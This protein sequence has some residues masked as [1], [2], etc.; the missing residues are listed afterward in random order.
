MLL[1]SVRWNTYRRWASSGAVEYLKELAKEATH[2]SKK[3]EEGDDTQDTRLRYKRMQMYYDQG[4]AYSSLQ[5]EEQGLM[6]MLEEGDKEL[7]EL[8]EDDLKGV[9]DMMREVE[10]SFDGVLEMVDDEDKAD[11]TLE[12]SGGAGGQEADLFAK[13][14]FDVYKDYCKRMGWR[15]ED[16]T[17]DV[18]DDNLSEHHL[19][20]TLTARVSGT[21]VFK[22][23]KWESGVHRVQRIPQSESGGRTHTS[24]AGVKVL[25]TFEP[26]DITVSFPREDFKFTSS[27]NTGPGGQSVNSTNTL[28]I[29]KHI[30]TGMVMKE[31]SGRDLQNNAA[32]GWDKLIGRLWELEKEA[33]ISKKENTRSSLAFSLDRHNKIR[34]YNW[35]RQN[36]VDHRLPNTQNTVMLDEFYEGSDLD[37]LIERLQAQ[38]VATRRDGWLK[39]KAAELRTPPVT[40][41]KK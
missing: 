17:G 32:L 15:W 3:L 36:I 39:E 35:S 2:L 40:N 33:A 1:R 6:E 38:D 4:L 20:R 28:A 25:P 21:D 10:N 41:Q 9:R 27:R 8:A 23:L 12:L 31:G 16:L 19:E 14:L 26:D 11:V 7:M 34:T 18:G 22:Y 24:T 30:P 37:L 13:E 5:S 29:W